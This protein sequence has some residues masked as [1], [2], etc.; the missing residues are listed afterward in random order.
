M[1]GTSRKRATRF[2]VR[3]SA[4]AW[5]RHR[6][7]YLSRMIAS[8]DKLEATLLALPMGERARLEE[9]LISSL[10]ETADQVDTAWHAEVERQIDAYERGEVELIDAVV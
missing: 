9:R 1:S 4:V 6:G 7:G 10:E 8:L 5:V 3:R 2:C